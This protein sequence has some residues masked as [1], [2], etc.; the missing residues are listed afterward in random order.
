MTSIADISI[1]CDTEWRR[2]KQFAA[3]AAGQA[4][5]GGQVLDLQVV[6]CDVAVLHSAAVEFIQELLED[7]VDADACQ[8]VALL[9]VVVQG[10]RDKAFVA[11]FIKKTDRKMYEQLAAFTSKSFVQVLWR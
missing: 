6:R 1:L 8:K 10:F 7:V 11:D 2:L 9:D 3:Q 5:Q 4:L